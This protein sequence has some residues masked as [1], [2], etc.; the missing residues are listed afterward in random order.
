[1]FGVLFLLCFVGLF[2]VLII[3]GAEYENLQDQEFDIP[4]QTQFKGKCP[5][6]FLLLHFCFTLS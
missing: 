1:M 3:D 6:P 5:W 4:E 2:D